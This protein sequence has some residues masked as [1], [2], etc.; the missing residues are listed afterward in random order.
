MNNN[1]GR[2][3][4][5]ARYVSAAAMFSLAAAL[6]YFT[7][8]LVQVSREIPE[9]LQT[10]EDVNHQIS[11]VV[12]EVAEIRA[13]IPP[14][15]EEVKAT[16]KMIPPVL[17]EVRASREWAEPVIS[18]Y[19][20]TN[21]QIPHIL[22]EVRATREALPP[23]LKTVDGAADAVRDI[24][25]EIKAT[26]P[27]VPEILAEVEKTREAIPPMLDRADILVANARK[28]GKEA[29]RGAVSGVF[30]GILMAPFVF[31]GDVGKRLVGA[32]SSD[33]DRLS[34][35]D[36]AMVE[37]ATSEILNIGKPGDKKTW[38]NQNTGSSG[39]VKLLDISE[40]DGLDNE[41]REMEIMVQVQD[42]VLQK[43][44]VELCLNDEGKW[45]FQ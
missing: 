11:P 43:K 35:E 42:K 28:A 37:A 30:S 2:A 25:A 18:E 1:N 20:R 21:E 7:A 3:Q 40:E 29:S 17:A 44:T 36:Y 41:C 13:L 15:L 5:Y 22:Q 8:G 45:D 12:D 9:I 26:R 34:D 32:G 31:V 4:I 16:R 6:V 24:S 14:I 27:L 23:V 19:S 33:E 10:V 39:Y 38:V